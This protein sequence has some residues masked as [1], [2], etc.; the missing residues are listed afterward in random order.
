MFPM[1]A[2]SNPEADQIC[3]IK[4]TLKGSRPSIWRRALVPCSYSLGDLHRVIQAIMPW[5]DCHFHEFRIGDQ[6]YGI[7][8][9]EFAEPMREEEDV[10]LSELLT[11]RC[12][13]FVYVYDFGDG[14]QHRIDLEEVVRRDREQEYPVCIAGENAS[15][16]EDSGSLWGYYDKLR[17]LSDPQHPD[18]ESVK[19]WMPPGFDPGRFD[20]KKAN[21][22]LRL[23]EDDDD[24]ELGMGTEDEPL[25]FD[26]DYLHHIC[27][28]CQREIPDAAPVLGQGIKVREGIDLS[29]LEGSF[30]MLSVGGKTRTVPALVTASD[31]QAKEDGKDL[32]V[33]VCSDKCAKELDQA[34][35]ED[36]AAGESLL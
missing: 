25:S 4:I 9:P 14:W 27:G 15:P 2:P 5:G 35:Q 10:T 8:D 34:L 23:Y 16:P 11:P 20:P 17:I 3:R 24:E 32:M 12:M 13:S 21:V 22:L 1:I 36:K 29:P 30:V 28:W 19:E 7:P 26:P 33:M 6:H 18:H 31:S